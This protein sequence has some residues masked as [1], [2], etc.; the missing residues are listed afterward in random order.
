MFAKNLEIR[1][2]TVASFKFS[3]PDS[4]RVKHFL[5]FFLKEFG[6]LKFLALICNQEFI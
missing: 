4:V 3:E 1:I 5:L 2:I 6:S